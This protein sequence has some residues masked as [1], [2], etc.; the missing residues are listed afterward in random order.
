M[1]NNVIKQKHISAV[2]VSGEIFC[3]CVQYVINSNR[4]TISNTL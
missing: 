1:L 4:K 3:V 2:T